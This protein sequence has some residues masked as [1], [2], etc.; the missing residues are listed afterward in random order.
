MPEIT[1]REPQLVA[2]TTWG[3]PIEDAATWMIPKAASGAT[4]TPSSPTATALP[5]VPGLRTRIHSTIGAATITES[6]M[7]VV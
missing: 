7:A 1:L 5:T 2:R 6:A 4:T 3:Q